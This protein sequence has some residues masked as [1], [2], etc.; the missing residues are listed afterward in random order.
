MKQL[1]GIF[2]GMTLLVSNTHALDIG[3]GA[4][5]GT[6]GPGV[7]LSIAL[8]KTI[9]ARVSLTSVDIEDESE[10]ITIGDP[11]FEGDI[12]SLLNLD[13]GASALLFDWYVFNGTFHV[14]A[15]FLKNNGAAD[16]SG[17][18]QSAVELDGVPLDPG[19]INGAITGSVSA[20]EDYEPYIGIGWGRKAGDNA[21]ISLSIEL[22]IALMSPESSLNASV[23]SGGPNGYDQATLDSIL[24][25]VENDVNDDLSEFE[26]W[27][28]LSIGFNYAF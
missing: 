8:T 9:N 28:V 10:S 26:A 4:K 5:I 20:A 21:G 18:L 17:T 1:I 7:D 19:D 25:L 23:N 16:L 24:V 27:P 3:I 2:L 13:F 12:D 22:G 6:V 11:G 14:T 15:G